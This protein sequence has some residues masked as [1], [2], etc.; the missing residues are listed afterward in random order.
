MYPTSEMKELTL[1]VAVRQYLAA[2]K[3]RRL[4]PS[5][6]STYKYILDRFVAF[7]QPDNPHPTDI[8][9]Q[10]IDEFLASFDDV[11]D[12]RLLNYHTALSAMWT[13]FLKRKICEH[14]IVRMV[15]APR[16]PQKLIRPFTKDEYYAMMRA[17][18]HF[19]WIGIICRATMSTL[20]GTG[21]RVSELCHLKFKDYKDGS[22]FVRSGKGKKDRRVPVPITTSKFIEA[23]LANR[24]PPEP[25]DFLLVGARGEP[26]LRHRVRRQVLLV[27]EKAGVDQP[28]SHRFRHF[29]GTEWLRAGGDIVTLKKLMGHS[30]IRTT[31]QYLYIQTDDIENAFKRFNPL[32]HLERAKD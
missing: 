22:L 17:S 23:H 3:T 14:H 19:P 27:G 1:D 21:L 20:A 29:F 9:P 8:G 11:G 16:P 6:I 13:W 18:Y 5:T 10:H 24:P 2:Q 12:K 32:D 31:E 26:L 15:D 25:D 7:M 4:S 30:D 28:T